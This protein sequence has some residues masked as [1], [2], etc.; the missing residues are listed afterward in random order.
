MQQQIL[1][2]IPEHL[3]K[4]TEET[5]DKYQINTVFRA[6]H[7]LSQVTHESGDFKHKEENLSY[8]ENGLLLT[9]PK[10]FNAE[11]ARTYARKPE[12]IANRIYANR[13]GNGNEQSGDG[14]RHRGFGFIQTTG[15]ENQEKVMKELG[16][17][18]PEE[19]KEDRNA[20]LSAGYFWNNKK[21][22]LAADKGL[23]IDV[24]RN[25]RRK[26]NGGEI[27]LQDCIDRLN[28]LCEK[29]QYKA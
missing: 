27:G 10:Y 28:K 14:W 16:L 11:T 6:V 8:S 26:V 21:L 3:R 17:A 5:F 1:L 24:I 18:K 25:V 9:F 23:T 12:Q 7:F 4:H 2:L 13:M 20:M 15:K 29:L 19:L 22:N